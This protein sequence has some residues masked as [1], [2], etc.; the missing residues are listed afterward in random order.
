MTCSSDESTFP[1]E[2]LKNLDVERND[3]VSFVV[4]TGS[5]TEA[6]RRALV[7]VLFSSL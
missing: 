2:C 3:F 5:I 6:D 1:K 7:S 4:S